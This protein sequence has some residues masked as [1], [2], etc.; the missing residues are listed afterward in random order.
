MSNTYKVAGGIFAVLVVVAVIVYLVW[1]RPDEPEPEPVVVE[2][3]ATPTPAPEPTPTLAERL[4]E[5]LAGV[6]LKTSDAVVRELVEGLSSNPKLAA[7]LANEDLIR[8][9]TATVD[10]IADGTS[11]RD[12][13]DF[14]RPSSP[15]RAV[16]KR[17]KFYV[18]SS[19]YKRYDLPVEIFSSLDTEDAVTLYRE[20]RPLIDEAYREISPPGRVFHNRLMI[21]I[22]HLLAVR[23]P[24][25]ELELEE[26]TVATFKYA[27]TELEELSDAQR[28][29]LRMGPGNVRKVQAKLRELRDALQTAEE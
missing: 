15:F 8:R 13:V 12:H 26:R 16:S 17:G 5:R 18:H 4:S 21:A 10:N 20:L 14:L 24:S 3:P 28:H 23:P 27:D 9:F 1:L 22:D 11:P 29:L 7:W 2:Q 19:S 6:T 25:G